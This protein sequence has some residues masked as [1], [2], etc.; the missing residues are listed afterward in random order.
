MQTNARNRH[1]RSPMSHLITNNY[2]HTVPSRHTFGDDA[3][4]ATTTTTTTSEMETAVPAVSTPILGNQFSTRTKTSLLIWVARCSRSQLAPLTRGSARLAGTVKVSRV[5][6]HA[7]RN[8]PAD[9]LIIFSFFFSLVS[10]RSIYSPGRR[11]NDLVRECTLTDQAKHSLNSNLT[12]PRS[13]KRFREEN[14]QEN[15]MDISASTLTENFCYL[16]LSKNLNYKKK[17]IAKWILR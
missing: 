13:L 11:R 14:E 1:P 7:S 5:Y 10:P 4:A 16:T 3:A 15:V 2:R 12:N 8:R 9:T 6:L 17:D